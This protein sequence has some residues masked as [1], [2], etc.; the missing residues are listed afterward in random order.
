[1]T[2]YRQNHWASVRRQIPNTRGLEEEGS[3]I[4]YITA[5]H[6][7]DSRSQRAKCVFNFTFHPVY[8]T[9]DH[10]MIWRFAIFVAATVTISLVVVMRPRSRVENWSVPAEMLSGE[11]PLSIFV[12]TIDPEWNAETTAQNCIGCS[13]K[14][15]NDDD[16]EPLIHCLISESRFVT[17]SRKNATFIF[18]PIY[19]NGRR[20]LELSSE[21]SGVRSVANHDSFTRWKG[22]R[23]VVV[24]SYRSTRPDVGYLKFSDQ[25][26]VICTNMTIDFVR[27]NRWMNSRHILVPPLQALDEYPE[28]P[29]S[30]KILCIGASRVAVDW[31]SA[32]HIDLID[33]VTNKPRLIDEISRSTFTVLFPD[34]NV[35][36][37]LLY[38][39]I[40]ARSV[41]VLVSPPF[42]PAFAN[43][44]I[45]YSRISIRVEDPVHIMSR[46]EA[47]DQT[48][49]SALAHSARYLMW[50]KAP[51]DVAPDN[52][53]GVLFD[54]LNTR[55]KVLRPTLRRTFIGSDTYIP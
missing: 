27:E 47:F 16:L 39:I 42:L 45:N 43:T 32:N 14:F 29:K 54:Y 28:K 37:F 2:R 7:L 15:Q 4:T 49:L 18:V 13:C 11:K 33:N 50:P 36:P 35:E 44:H 40:R 17:S 38:E 12:E 19:T 30:R 6:P 52:A 3:T 46:I 5:H 34:A 8:R 51:S 26:L 10:I 21:L 20:K 25:H 53:A 24:D 55:H 9:G 1:M 22:S 48:A 41:P 31:A 23:H